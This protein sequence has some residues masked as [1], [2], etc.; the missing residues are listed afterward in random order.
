MG[1]AYPSFGAKRVINV[2][3]IDKLP[4]FY[5]FSNQIYYLFTFHF[6][7]DGYALRVRNFKFYARF[8]IAKSVSSVAE[9]FFGYSRL[10]LIASVR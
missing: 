5:V 2:F 1:G 8:K 6:Y 7:S 10:L 9:V 4:T 3:P